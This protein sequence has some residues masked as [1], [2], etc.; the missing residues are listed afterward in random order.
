[1][2]LSE[3]AAGG[4]PSVQ[5]TL[6]IGRHGPVGEEPPPN[7]SHIIVI[8]ATSAQ[9]PSIGLA[10]ETR[11]LTD[12]EVLI[13]ADTTTSIPMTRASNREVRTVEPGRAFGRIACETATTVRE[14]A[15]SGRP[16]HVDI[17][18]LAA[19]VETAAKPPVARLLHVLV[20]HLMAVDSQTQLIA[21]LERADPSV[22]NA[23][24][25]LF[26]S[27]DHRS[28]RNGSAP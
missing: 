25:P 14:L 22:S 9:E 19:A 6:I 28:S 21:Y 2:L 16:V 3:D 20:G 1:M 12:A 15:A 26:D 18:G 10:E 23:L 24:T 5:N 7:T 17:M 8:L 11:P 4:G 13:I 27:V